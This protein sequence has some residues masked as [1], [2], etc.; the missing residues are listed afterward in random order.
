MNPFPIKKHQFQSG[1]LLVACF[2]VPETTILV[3]KAD[4]AVED[5]GILN[6]ISIQFDGRVK[7]WRIRTDDASLWTLLHKSEEQPHIPEDNKNE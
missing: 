5:P 6:V 7:R 3:L 2:Q 4:V 1:N